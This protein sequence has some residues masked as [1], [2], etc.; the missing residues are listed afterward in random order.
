MPG[1]IT[2]LPYR[3]ETGITLAKGGVIEIS[4]TDDSG[5][6]CVVY[7]HA[8]D[9]PQLIE[10]INSAMDIYKSESQENSEIQQP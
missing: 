4:Q 7:I 10:A 1:L 9:A 5:E 6:N 2:V 8:K 3:C